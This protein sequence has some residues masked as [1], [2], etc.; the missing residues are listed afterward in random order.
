MVSSV[1]D[2]QQSGQSLSEL[3]NESEYELEERADR[4]GS[5]HDETKGHDD[6]GAK[7]H[8][9]SPAHSG[10]VGTRLVHIAHVL[11]HQVNLG[12]DTVRLEVGRP[13][14]IAHVKVEE[15]QVGLVHLL[16]E[17]VEIVVGKDPL[18]GGEVLQNADCL[19]DS[20]L[21]LDE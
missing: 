3:E 4:L 10:I 21:K 19:L 13:V 1:L 9:L 18:L 2:W 8:L 17:H 20:L 11:F 15:L 5:V 6:H 7:D 14:E 16:H 12:A